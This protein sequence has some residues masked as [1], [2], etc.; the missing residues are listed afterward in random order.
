MTTILT[1]SRPPTLANIGSWRARMLRNRTVS[2]A[3][4][5]INKQTIRSGIPDL[6][7]LSSWIR[8]YQETKAEYQIA[9]I[10]NEPSTPQLESSVN[11]QFTGASLQSEDE[12]EDDVVFTVSSG[13]EDEPETTPR[14]GPGSVLSPAHGAPQM[15][16]EDDAKTISPPLPVKPP[17]VQPAPP[18]SSLLEVERKLS[19]LER[20]KLMSIATTM[21]LWADPMAPASH[22]DRRS[23]RQLTTF[24]HSNSH[25]LFRG[26]RLP[27]IVLSL[28]AIKGQLDPYHHGETFICVKG[29]SSNDEITRFHTVMS[30]KTVRTQYSPL[31]LCYDRSEVTFASRPESRKYYVKPDQSRLSLCGTTLLTEGTDGSWVSTVGGLI[32]I[33]DWCYMLTASNHGLSS[34]EQPLEEDSASV[35]TLVNDDFDDDITSA[36]VLQDEKVPMMQA[37]SEA[38][39]APNISDLE[40]LRMD[41]FA[42]ETPQRDARNNSGGSNSTSGWQPLTNN[43]DGRELDVWDVNWQL[44]RVHESRCLPNFISIPSSIPAPQCFWSGYLTEHQPLL[45][46]SPALIM[47]GHS[48]FVPGYVIGNPSFL[49]SKNKLQEVWTIQLYAGFNLRKGDSGSWVIDSS[50][51][52]LG[53]ITA[54][55]KGYAYMQPFQQTL[56]EITEKL[57]PRKPIRLPQPAGMLL[58][59]AK[60]HSTGNVSIAT[61]YAAEAMSNELPHSRSDYLA[62]TLRAVWDTSSPSAKQ[63]LLRIMCKY[64]TTLGSKLDQFE[65]WYPSV[66]QHLS[67]DENYYL[68]LLHD[69]YRMINPIIIEYGSRSATTASQSFLSYISSFFLLFSYPVQ[70]DSLC[71]NTR[72][73]QTLALR[74]KPMSWYQTCKSTLEILILILLIPI[75]PSW[76]LSGEISVVRSRAVGSSIILSILKSN[77][78]FFTDTTVMRNVRSRSRAYVWKLRFIALTAVLLNAI[79]T[80]AASLYLYHVPIAKLASSDQTSGHPAQVEPPAAAPPPT[81]AFAIECGALLYLATI[82]K[83]T[84][85]IINWEICMMIES[86]IQTIISSIVLYTSPKKG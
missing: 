61:N 55:S 27:E 24:L 85:E 39:K 43:D 56:Q 26:Q 46:T 42:V 53:S 38:P 2:P 83:Y 36:L 41:A 23:L 68:D 73:F 76:Y 78:G 20:L 80:V 21:R 84:T 1:H 9:L 86:C 12:E 16:T 29:L 31:K 66:S 7:G 58:R 28:V 57:N 4:P 33:D 77:V 15:E 82:G 8:Q 22:K 35:V 18:T 37:K 48:G 25:E 11:S 6:S 30:Q 60:L 71:E 75:L 67:D 52:V 19:P 69:L 40:L 10:E 5:A 79:V 17:A 14:P 63:Q 59:L 13:D 3:A 44:V 72:R 50:R 70:P 54:I 32:E 47:T 65:I 51:R 81:V 34:A 45:S 64:G 49:M 62:L 74:R